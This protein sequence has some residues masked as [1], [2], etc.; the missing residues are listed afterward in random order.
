MYHILYYLEILYVNRTVYLCVSK[1]CHNKQ[2]HSPDTELTTWYLQ[3]K[4]RDC[5]IVTVLL[6]TIE[7]QRL[8]WDS[9]LLFCTTEIQRLMWDSN[10][11]V[12]YNWNT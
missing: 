9:S 11:T 3:L 10:S 1:D 4:C 12:L 8:I 5:E 2:K 6:R 7:T